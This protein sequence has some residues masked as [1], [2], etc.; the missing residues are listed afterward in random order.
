M[1]DN[2]KQQ[3]L[4]ERRKARESKKLEDEELGTEVSGGSLKNVNYT[5]TG[6]ITTKIK[7]KI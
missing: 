5:K 4:E 7:E 1:A 6:N 3:E 2:K